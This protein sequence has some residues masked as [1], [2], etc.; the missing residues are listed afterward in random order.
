M[1]FKGLTAAE[2]RAGCDGHLLIPAL[3][4]GAEPIDGGVNSIT[5]RDTATGT[6]FTDGPKLKVRR[7]TGITKKEAESAEKF[8][9]PFVDPFNDDIP[10]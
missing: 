7:R 3:M 9:A 6:T 1:H 5:Y 10:F 2:Q 8:N 4:P